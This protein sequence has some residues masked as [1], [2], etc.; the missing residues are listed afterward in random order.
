MQEKETLLTGM[1][2]DGTFLIEDGKITRPLRDVRFT[3]SALRILEATEAL[4][5]ASKLVTDGEFYGVRH[6]TGVVAPGLRASGFRVTGSTV[7]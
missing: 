3:D 7:A 6:A 5:Q 1:T 2:R 4:T